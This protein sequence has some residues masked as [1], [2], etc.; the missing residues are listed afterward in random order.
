MAERVYITEKAPDPLPSPAPTLHIDQD[1]D[2]E[3]VQLLKSIDTKLDA[4]LVEQGQ[5]PDLVIR[6]ANA[7]R[8]TY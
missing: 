4:V 6:R 7:E 1:Q 2:S 5:D 8:K 3:V